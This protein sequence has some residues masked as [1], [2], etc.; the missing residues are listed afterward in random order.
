MDVYRT[1]QRE[2]LRTALKARGADLTLF[3]D[4]NLDKLWD[5]W[6]RNVRALSDAAREGL[7]AAGLP[8]GLIDHILALKGSLPAAAEYGPQD[9][10][11]RLRELLMA[12]R[13][14]RPNEATLQ[15]IVRRHSSRLIA[16]SSTETALQLYEEAKLLPGPSTEAEILKQ[17]GLAVDGPAFPDSSLSLLVAM[18]AGGCPR[19]LKMLLPVL[20][21]AGSSSASGEAGSSA[22]ASDAAGGPEAAACRAL[23][24][25]KPEAV[26]LVDAKVITFTLGPEHSATYSH[27]PGVYAAVL[28]PYYAGTVAKLPPIP[29]QVL[30]AAVQRMVEALEWIH[31]VDFVHMDV[32]ADNIFIDAAGRWWLGDFGSAVRTGSAIMSTTRWFAP[33]AATIKAAAVPQFDWHMLAVAMVIEALRSVGLG[34]KWQ[35]ML[36]DG[37]CTPRENILA[38]LKVLRGRMVDDAVLGSLHSLVERAEV[39]G[40]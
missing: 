16:A 34:N 2:H 40:V 33:P 19:V 17:G 6:Y 1:Q 8:P 24:H 18:D 3:D 26:P 25:G 11:K 14:D 5:N 10:L 20:P 15:L 31:R 39:K 9:Y 7:S 28:M 4:A 37:G 12:A 22:A 27:Y 36:I 23:C 38:A 21:I 32:K 13:I 35:E 29:L 30:P